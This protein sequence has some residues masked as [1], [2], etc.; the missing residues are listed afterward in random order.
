MCS[1]VSDHECWIV[2]LR[3]FRLLLQL[4]EREGSCCYIMAPAN[5]PSTLRVSVS[6]AADSFYVT[7]SKPALAA[8]TASES[9]LVST[10][11]F[12][13]SGKCLD[14]LVDYAAEEECQTPKSEAHKIPPVLSCPPAP[15]KPKWFPVKRKIPASPLQGFY[16]LSD[17]DLQSLF[18]SDL[19]NINHQHMKNGRN[20]SSQNV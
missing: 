11:N 1:R 14:S 20:K 7:G 6:P 18:G 17:S 8:R 15:R 2:V 19:Q 10:T 3:T 12:G 4:E 16:I 9:I 5:R 13:D